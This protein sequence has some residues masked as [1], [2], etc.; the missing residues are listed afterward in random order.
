[1][2]DFSSQYRLRVLDYSALEHILKKNYLES[3][4]ETANIQLNSPELNLLLLITSEP[5]CIP[6]YQYTLKTHVYTCNASQ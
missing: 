4:S 5:L 1:M 3:T 6:T 2:N